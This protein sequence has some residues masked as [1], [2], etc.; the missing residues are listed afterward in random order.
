MELLQAKCPVT[1][2]YQACS[3]KLLTMLN[4]QDLPRVVLESLKRL[5]GSGTVLDVC[6][7][8]WESNEAELRVSGDIFFTWQY[9]IRWA[10]QQL[11]NDG[12]LQP[13]TRGAG[14]RWRLSDTAVTRP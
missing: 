5:G 10:A 7:D 8:V 9:D 2:T 4:K 12:S 13:T 1:R 14:S 3:A 6:K 11:R